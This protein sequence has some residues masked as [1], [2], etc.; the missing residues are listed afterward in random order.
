MP[1]A[2]IAGLAKQVTLAVEPQEKEQAILKLYAVL[3]QTTW[4]AQ[5]G[6]PNQGWSTSFT[7]I[8]DLGLAKFLKHIA[9]LVIRRDKGY[10]DLVGLPCKQLGPEDTTEKHALPHSKSPD[11]EPSQK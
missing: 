4:V 3:R 5:A 11:A 10:S 8:L 2:G 7:G 9:A 1:A 6:G